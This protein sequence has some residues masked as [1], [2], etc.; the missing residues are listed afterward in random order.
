MP[1]PTLQQA[2][3]IDAIFNLNDATV[4][5]VTDAC[6]QEDTTIINEPS[7]ADLP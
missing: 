2:E 5:K 4:D 6:P 1:A 7:T 3:L